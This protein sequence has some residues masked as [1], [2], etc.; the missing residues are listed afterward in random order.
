MPRHEAL[1]PENAI[2]DL[3]SLLGSS[4]ATRFLLNNHLGGIA[5]HTLDRFRAAAEALYD[6]Y[7]FLKLPPVPCDVAERAMRELEL[8]FEAQ[9]DRLKGTQGSD[10]QRGRPRTP[11]EVRKL[12]IELHG[13]GVEWKEIVAGVNSAHPRPG[14]PWT[15]EML[16]KLIVA[17]KKN[18]F[19]TK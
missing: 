2:S 16:R 17:K 7:D 9:I 5:P 1:T 4:R 14:K 10:K 8:W 3:Q 12:V 6:R 19:T 15:K 11:D 18:I 13:K